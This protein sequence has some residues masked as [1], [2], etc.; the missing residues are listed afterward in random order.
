MPSKEQYEYIDDR[1]GASVSRTHI[2]SLEGAKLHNIPCFWISKGFGNGEHYTIV[3]YQDGYYIAKYMGSTYAKPI[4]IL[5]S[6]R[7]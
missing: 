3:R 5:Q 2:F 6:V 4:P 7:E 1:L